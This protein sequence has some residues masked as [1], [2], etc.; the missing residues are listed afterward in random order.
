MVKDLLV[1]T[2]PQKIL[3]FLLEYS[4][5]DFIEKEIQEAV[6]IS[7]SGT[8]YALRSLV[9][10]TLL[11]RHKR[12]K[13]HFYTLNH[14]HP[15]IKQLKVLKTIMEIH[16]FLKELEKLSFKIILFGSSS[17][18]E[19][20]VDSDI[21]LFILSRHKDEIENQIKRYTSKRKIQGIIRNNLKYTEMKQTDPVFYEEVQQ[22]IVLWE[23]N[24]ES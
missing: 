9:K 19:N 24:N 13:I 10:S 20:T 3:D 14:K 2:N 1:A 5:K 17:R 7:R 22:G 12:G 21:D 11:K 15:L 4:F 23:R 18:G 8:N 16:P 6:K